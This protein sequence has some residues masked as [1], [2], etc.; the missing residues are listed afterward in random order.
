MDS[1][2][3]YIFFADPVLGQYSIYNDVGSPSSPEDPNAVFEVLT[4][5][6]I[7]PYKLLSTDYKHEYEANDFTFRDTIG[8]GPA[9]K[10][11]KTDCSLDSL[12]NVI[13]FL[14]RINHYGQEFQ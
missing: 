12:N 10:D 4:G 3:N 11:F 14:H 8:C 13:L 2:G 1:F 9:F 6:V 5:G 7:A